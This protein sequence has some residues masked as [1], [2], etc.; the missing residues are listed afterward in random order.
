MDKEKT[1]YPK[2]EKFAVRIV[3]LSRYLC[4]KKKEYIISKQI[5]RSGTSI[6]ANLSEA[7]CAISKND[8]L[9]KIYI[10]LKETSETA[11]WLRL[12]RETDYLTEK[13]F[14]SIYNDCNEIERMLSASTKT[15]KRQ[16]VNVKK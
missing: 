12:L 1:V 3:K 5:L 15:A 4:D 10:A 16:T 11:G 7:N 14:D 9:A 6:M 8:W 2:S 13:E